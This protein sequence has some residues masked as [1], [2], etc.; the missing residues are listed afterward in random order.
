[1]KKPLLAAFLLA[2]APLFAGC[3]S[4]GQYGDRLAAQDDVKEAEVKAIGE[5]ALKSPAAPQKSFSDQGITPSEY[6]EV[7]EG[8]RKSEVFR[9][10]N[11]PS[12]SPRLVLNRLS[13]G[14]LTQI[15]EWRRP[16]S[17]RVRVTF[18]GGVVAAKEQTGL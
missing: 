2:A 7:A 12:Y 11:V 9:I 16:I 3:E 18:I 4:N 17:S 6:Q 15:Y 14:S 10:F 5:A 8:M 1:M 13:S